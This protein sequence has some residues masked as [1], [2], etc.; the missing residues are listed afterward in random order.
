MIHFAGCILVTDVS[1]V[2]NSFM[3][4]VKQSKSIVRV[5]LDPEDYS[6][7]ILLIVGKLSSVHWAYHLRSP[8][9]SY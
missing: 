8:E 1:K 2:R 6:I 4:M 7:M 3:F 9:I 5:L